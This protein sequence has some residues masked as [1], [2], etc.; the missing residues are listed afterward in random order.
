MNVRF[1]RDHVQN[2]LHS[3]T[4]KL[5]DSPLKFLFK[6]ADGG[7]SLVAIT[8]EY[9]EFSSPDD[10]T[11]VRAKV[12]CKSFETRRVSAIS[13]H[14]TIPDDEVIDVQPKERIDSV[15][16]SSSG[17][18]IIKEDD[19]GKHYSEHYCLLVC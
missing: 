13:I 3:S 5:S 9:E 6:I 1:S 17:E 7:H 11:L 10:P 8:L 4:Q 14:I 12:L 15:M 16:I 2:Y 18:I 19:D